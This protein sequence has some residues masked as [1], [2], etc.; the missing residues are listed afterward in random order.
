MSSPWLV[1]ETIRMARGDSNYMQC[2]RAGARHG[3]LGLLASECL[4]QFEIRPAHGC[5]HNARHEICIR[6][7]FTTS[8]SVQYAYELDANAVFDRMIR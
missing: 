3:Y 8:M 1:V 6:G 2:N 7:Y 4:Q 5:P